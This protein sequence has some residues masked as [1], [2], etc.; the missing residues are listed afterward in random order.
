[1]SFSLTETPPATLWYFLNAASKDLQG[2]FRRVRA[3]VEPSLL[4]M[5]H[6]TQDM[7]CRLYQF[8]PLTEGLLSPLVFKVFPVCLQFSILLPIFD[9]IPSFIQRTATLFFGLLDPKI[10]SPPDCPF[11]AHPTSNSSKRL[12]GLPPEDIQK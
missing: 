4:F 2:L 11:Y 1:M 5:F 10:R 12:L 9:P 8:N 3:L 6:M 7:A